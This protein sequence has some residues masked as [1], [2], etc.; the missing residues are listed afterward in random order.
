MGTQH[1]SDETIA[2]R[3]TSGSRW[4]C[5]YYEAAGKLRALYKKCHV[6]RTAPE[7]LSASAALV[8]ADRSLS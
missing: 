1:E 7:W 2:E 8:A 6:R 4:E 5:M 3:F